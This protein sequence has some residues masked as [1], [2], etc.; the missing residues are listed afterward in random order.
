MGLIER[1]APVVSVSALCWRCTTDEHTTYIA[2]VVRH[3]TDSTCLRFDLMCPRGISSGYGEARWFN[4]LCF[5]FA[6]YMSLWHQSKDPSNHE[7]VTTRQP[8]VPSGC[9]GDGNHHWPV[10]DEFVAP[11]HSDALPWWVQPSQ[12]LQLPFCGHKS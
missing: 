2:V 5:P 11:R 3:Q 12:V 10:D 1:P 9:V 7:K 8:S 6:L 4:L